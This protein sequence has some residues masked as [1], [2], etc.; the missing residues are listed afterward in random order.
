MQNPINTVGGKEGQIKKG[1]GRVSKD[2]KE[3]II[4]RIKE[5]G[6]SI[7]DAALDHGVSTKTIYGWLAHGVTKAPS[8]S[9]VAK[10]K[11]EVKMLT[12][13]VGQMTIKLSQT[14]KKS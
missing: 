7:S 6:V 12:E 11:K 8:W 10:L 14:Q 4:K 9:E 13:L 2:V 1:K 5:D 3:Q